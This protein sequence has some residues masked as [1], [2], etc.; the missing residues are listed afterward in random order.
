MDLKS[1]EKRETIAMQ[2]VAVTAVIMMF[3]FAM[4]FIGAKAE[5]EPDVRYIYTGTDVYPGNDFVQ[6]QYFIRFLKND[7]GDISQ[8]VI[9]S[10]SPEEAGAIRRY[11]RGEK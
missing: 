9:E 4:L 3:V 5:L 7:N 1:I 6:E 11:M 10:S 2:I 8:L